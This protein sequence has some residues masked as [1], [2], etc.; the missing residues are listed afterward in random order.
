[1]MIAA[2][3]ILARTVRVTESLGRPPEGIEAFTHRLPEDPAHGLELDLL[4]HDGTRFP[5]IMAVSLIQ[6]PV[7]QR[8]L[9]A[10]ALINDLSEQRRLEDNLRRSNTLFNAVITSTD[11]AIIAVDLEGTLILYNPAAERMEGY[12]ASE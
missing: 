1:R 8:P 9:G 4:R 6:D 10:V 2:D 7:E 11:Q 5:G 3:E 12:A